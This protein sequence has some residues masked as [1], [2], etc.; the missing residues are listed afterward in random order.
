MNAVPA[1]RRGSAA[2]MVSTFQN[3]GMTLSIGVFFSLMIAG[4]A[5][6]LP[7]AMHSGLVAQHVPDATATRLAGLPPVGS[8]FAAFLGYNPLANLLGPGVLS[9][10]PPQS[11]AS[12]TG[13]QF[14]PHLIG[15]PFHSGL[16]IV[17]TLAIAMSLVAAGASLMRG[18]RHVHEPLDLRHGESASAVRNVA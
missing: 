1:T 7:T 2:G 16:V 9:S 14:F 11:A 8:L 17:F 15:A 12:L 3:A 4:L 6:T 13:H 18:R 5:G 10:L